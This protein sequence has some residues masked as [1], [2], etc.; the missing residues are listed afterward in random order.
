MLLLAFYIRRFKA[1]D[2]VDY[3]SC[4]LLGVATYSI[5]YAL[6]MSS[7]KLET[8]LLFYKM[9]YIGIAFI[10]PFF[11]LFSLAYTG[12]KNWITPLTKIAV[13]IIPLLT[14]VVVFT[15][16]K[17]HLFHEITYVSASGPYYGLEFVPGP[18]YWLHEI[19]SSL[20]ILISIYFFFRTWI[21]D[22]SYFSKQLVILV[23][24]STISFSVYLLYLAGFFP[25][26]L[27]PVP[28]A[29]I[30]GALMVYI[31]IFRYGL[32][33]IA[34]IARSYLFENVPSGVI[35]LDRR[36]RMVDINQSAAKY[37]DISSK[38]MGKP[39]SEVFAFWPQ[40]LEYSHDFSHKDKL[41]LKHVFKG[42]DH[43]FAADILPLY[44]GQD[45]LH[46]KMVVLDD[47]TDRML[48]EEVLVRGKLM[49]EEANHM[50]SEFL[51]NMSHELRTPLNAIIGFSQLLGQETEGELNDLQLKHIGII[52]TA[53][54]HLLDL[55]NDI[56]DISKLEAGK[57]SLECDDFSVKDALEEVRRLIYPLA[58]KKRIDL[59]VQHTSGDIQ[60]CA[61]QQKLKQIMYNLLSN[62][63]KFTHENGKVTVS[64][65]HLDDAIQVSVSDTGI[66]IAR[67]RQEDIF[68]PFKQ[69]ESSFS[70]K[71][72]GT[73]LGLALV[74]EFV[75]MHNGCIWVE[76]EEGKGSTFTFVLKDQRK[77][78]DLEK[79]SD[80]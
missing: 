68:Q 62:A 10:P 1:T 27:D 24:C 79:Q 73:G 14:L 13:F 65:E 54:K 32:F 28:F 17:H 23:V 35:V 64:Y 2:G 58:A 40:L 74:K 41:E 47:I 46:G 67:D 30:L 60:I 34:P 49:A 72:Q 69:I 66:G 63:V 56:L 51:A 37:M 15:I 12:K 31:G 42:K 45:D 25:D 48:A 55:I 33:N 18:Y 19:Y 8:A 53:G 11:L 39:A 3:F 71:Y 61:D 70:R 26:G 5:F 80:E 4:F 57:M 36:E 44:D 76:S 6:E 22:R 59:I 7:G 43:W 38:D 16:E 52:E 21:Q 20:L 9:E 78:F 77:G 50:K 29:F 75:E